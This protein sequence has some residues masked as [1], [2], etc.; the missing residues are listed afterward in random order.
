MT[1][2]H[3]IPP[4]VR[5]LI[6]CPR[7]RGELEDVASGLLCR[8]DSVVFPVES[9]VP[10]LADECARKANQADLGAETVR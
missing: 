2:G 4:E 3:A 6:V 7:C 10:F 1:A 8:A 9:G 5:D